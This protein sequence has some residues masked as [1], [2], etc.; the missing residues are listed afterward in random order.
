MLKNL[1]VGKM[2]RAFDDSY[3]FVNKVVLDYIKENPHITTFQILDIGCS[4]GSVTKKYLKGFSNYFVTG[5]DAHE[6][7]GIS[8]GKYVQFNLEEI[9]YPFENEAFD[10]VLVGQTIEHLLNKDNLLEECHR[11][12]KKGG[13]FVCATENIASFDNIASLLLGQEPHVQH[14][15]S[16]VHTHSILSPHYMTKV[17]EETGNRYLHKNVNSYYGLLRLCKVNGFD[18]LKIKSFGNLFGLFEKMF[19]IYNRIIAVYGKK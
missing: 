16:K 15:G 5:M 8:G 9:P 7:G 14:T 18:N 11:V 1:F 6:T 4:D 2:E 10:I 12:L 13:L 3:K 19:P 17:A